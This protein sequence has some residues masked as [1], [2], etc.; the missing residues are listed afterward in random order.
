MA[1]AKQKAKQ[2]A[3]LAAKQTRKTKAKPKAKQTRKT[4]AKAKPASAKA[5][6]AKAKAAAAKPAKPRSAQARPAQ[7]RSGGNGMP[8]SPPTNATGMAPFRLVEIEP[9]K[10][11]LLLTEFEPASEVF[12][13]AGIEG[14]GY[15]WEGVARY[16]LEVVAP[17][18]KPRVGLDPEAS[19]F[20]AYGEDRAALEQLG[21][22]L[23]R[24]FN[25][26]TAL[27]AVIEEVGP[28]GFEA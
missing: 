17:D 15:S 9:N 11:S 1:K 27:A 10:F 2:K 7:P 16:V 5:R 19:M 18:L 13:A 14:G 8:A 26:K 22:Q 12:D 28:A 4:K 20:C 21:G 24:L 25:D 6:P 23:S 3:K